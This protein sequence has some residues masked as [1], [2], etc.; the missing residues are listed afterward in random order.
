[1]IW[2]VPNPSS[3]DKLAPS[4]SMVSDFVTSRRVLTEY[5]PTQIR[6]VLPLD[7][8]SIA[9]WIVV[10]VAPTKSG[11]AQLVPSPTEPEAAT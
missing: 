6:T 8:A 5:V 4:P 1:M 7:A 11:E 2:V 10:P 3:V 9:D